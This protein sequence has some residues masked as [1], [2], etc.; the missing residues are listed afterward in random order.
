[1]IRFASLFSGGGVLECG[2]AP[3]IR[4]VLAVEYD[5]AIA[6]YY[7]RN[8]GDH[9]IAADVCSV[10]F[11]ALGVGVDH[12]HASPVCTRA[13]VANANGGESDLDIATAQATIRAL[14]AFNPR[15]FTL[16]NVYPYRNFAAFK[17]ICNA[18][19]R[20]GYWW[21][22]AHVNSA[23]Y[24]IPQTRQRLW[25]WARR[26]AM[27]MAL[28]TPQPWRGWYE[29]IADLIP[30]LPDT[31]FAPWQ[32]ARLPSELRETVMPCYN[33]T[34]DEREGFGMRLADR[35]SYLVTA[36]STL[37]KAKA[38]VVDGIANDRGESVTIRDGDEAM[39]TMRA[40]AHKQLPRAF[41]VHHSEMRTDQIH[42]DQHA[43]MMTVTAQANPFRAYGNG[44]VVQLS[45]RCLA[46]FQGMPDTYELP[47]PRALACKIIGN[48]APFGALVNAMW[49]N[50]Q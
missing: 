28:P 45:P 9:V 3:H 37:G 44:R 38:F 22:I 42:R 19:T 30:D 2:L 21:N 46:R 36:N 35:P 31:E 50:D 18:L 13:S 15:A 40:S 26:D 10:D 4:P 17:L 33:N 7:R 29:A 48:G 39:F 8:H 14:E 6:E 47:E 49:E 5:A 23:D 41:V 43:S 24:G 27:L 20:L 16:E 34:A 25:L 32:L 1:M 12:L 11:A